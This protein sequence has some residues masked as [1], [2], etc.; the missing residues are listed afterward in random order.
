[1]FGKYGSSKCSGKV[2]TIKCKNIPDEVGDMGLTVD[3]IF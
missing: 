2:C 1:M 3:T